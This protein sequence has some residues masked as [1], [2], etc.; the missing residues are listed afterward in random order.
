VAAAEGGQRLVVHA[1]V[2]PDPHGT[3]IPEVRG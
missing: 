1:Q 2:R 3:T